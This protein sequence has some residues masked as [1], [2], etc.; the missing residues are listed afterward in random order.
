MTEKTTA[1]NAAE[2][3]INTSDGGVTINQSKFDGKVRISEDVIAQL[4]TKAL[5]SVDGVSPA[6]PGLMANLRL[7]R[8]IVNGV[9]ISIS[10]GDATEIV[11]D[12][13][14]SIK[15]GLRIPDVCWDVQ[16]AIKEQVERFTGY[17]IKSVNVFVQGVTFADKKSDDAEL[18]SEEQEDIVGEQL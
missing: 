1:D 5:A 7:G 12:A 18:A 4:A 14:V 11:I 10:D 9:R 16:E 15:Y 2:E 8:K 6:S 13:Y 3:N 17:V